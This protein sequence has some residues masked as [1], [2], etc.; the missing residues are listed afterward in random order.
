MSNICIDIEFLAGT[1]IKDAIDGAK[2]L[3]KKLD[4][5]YVKFEFNSVRFSVR[6]YSEYCFENIYKE[7]HEKLE[8]KEN[9]HIIV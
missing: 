5:A 7:F 2:E 9:K 8:A 6:P 1:S 3:G 4:V